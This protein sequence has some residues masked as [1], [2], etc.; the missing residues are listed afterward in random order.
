MRWFVVLASKL[1]FLEAVKNYDLNTFNR[2]VRKEKIAE[3]ARKCK[4]K[5]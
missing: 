4:N 1:I 2:K 5:G 3:N